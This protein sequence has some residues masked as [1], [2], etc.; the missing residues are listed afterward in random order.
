MKKAGSPKTAGS[1][2][3]GRGVQLSKLVAT[4]PLQ[5]LSV[6]GPAVLARRHSLG[7]DVFFRV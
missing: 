5:S 1:Q 7:V 4:S 3:H 6:L 2:M